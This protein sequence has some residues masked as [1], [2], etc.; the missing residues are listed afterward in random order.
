M[1]SGFMPSRTHIFFPSGGRPHKHDNDNAYHLVLTLWPNC[2]HTTT[3]TKKIQM[4]L[5]KRNLII[6]LN[7]II[8]I[9]GQSLSLGRVRKVGSV[10]AT[11]VRE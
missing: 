9:S 10:P 1:V 3:T 2:P 4:N 11:S 5:Q 6:A 8:H 7:I